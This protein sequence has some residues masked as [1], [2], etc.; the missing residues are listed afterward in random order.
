MYPGR[1]VIMLS[2]DKLT[3]YLTELQPLHYC[4]CQI[5]MKQE[6]KLKTL[7]WVIRNKCFSD[8]CPIM[9]HLIYTAAIH[10]NELTTIMTYECHFFTQFIVF[11]CQLVVLFLQCQ[12]SSKESIVDLI[13]QSLSC[14]LCHA[15]QR[16]I[17]DSHLIISSHLPH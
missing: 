11:F 3:F 13:C 17:T 8:I 5:I 7:F 9:C 14:R 2:L 15:Y 12:Y 10:H 6:A 1:G 16:E 4:N